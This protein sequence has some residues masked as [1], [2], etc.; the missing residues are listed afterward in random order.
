[1]SA[2]P[3][4]ELTSH[5][6]GGEAPCYAHLLEQPEQRPAPVDLDSVEGIEVLV[7]EFYRRVAVD[8]LLGP[9]FAGTEVDWAAHLPKMVEF[10][11]WQLLGVRGYEGQPF[12]VHREVAERYPLGAEQFGRWLE[13]FDD[14]ID[15]H[16]AGPIAELAHVRA[17]KMASALQRLLAL[18]SGD[19]EGSEADGAGQIERDDEGSAPVSVTLVGPRR[20]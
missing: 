7:R 9:V 20:S 18:R 4:H 17:A 16:F 13:L 5:E 2:L 14:T 10:W 12:P 19:I 6:L 15:E 1:M 11:S 8:D 3:S